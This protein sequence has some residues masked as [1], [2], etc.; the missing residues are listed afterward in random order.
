MGTPEK[1]PIAP[2][3]FRYRV[4]SNS[5]QQAL[6]DFIDP[7]IPAQLES[8]LVF[9]P[10]AI[11]ELLIPIIEYEDTNQ[12]SISGSLARCI[13]CGLPPHFWEY[14][15]YFKCESEKLINNG[16]SSALKLLRAL[17]HGPTD[18][19]LKISWKPI[20]DIVDR[21]DY[22]SRK[23]NIPKK[24]IS[25]AEQ[26]YIY[27]RCNPTLGRKKVPRDI[28]AYVAKELNIEL[29]T[30]Q[31][32][33]EEYFK[34]MKTRNSC[35]KEQ[36]RTLMSALVT[37]FGKSEKDIIKEVIPLDDDTSYNRETV[38]I[39][40][41]DDFEAKI[42][43]SQVPTNI[44]HTFMRIGILDTRHEGKEIFHIDLGEVGNLA[45]DAFSDKRS[46]N[47]SKIQDECT[48]PLTTKNGQIIYQLSQRA[49]DV[50]YE[51]DEIYTELDDLSDVMEV[52][53]RALRMNLLH[54]ISSMD[55]DLQS[56]STEF[57][58]DSLFKL[59]ESIQG[60]VNRNDTINPNVLHILQ[61]ELAL[62]LTINPHITV[63]FLRDS[64]LSSFIPGL[65]N[66]T[67]QQWNKI[68]SSKHFI[69]TA[70]NNYNKVPI[71]N[72]RTWEV[73]NRQAKLYQ[74]FCRNKHG[75]LH[76]NGV[77]R[78]INAIN[79]VRGFHE[80]ETVS[81]W[82]KYIDL[83]KNERVFYD[84]LSSGE[85]LSIPL[86]SIILTK[87]G[88][89]IIIPPES[90]QSISPVRSREIAE[91]IASYGPNREP[92][93]ETIKQMEKLYPYY[94]QAS[95]LFIPAEFTKSP[96]WKRDVARIYQIISKFPAG[97]TAREI[98][99]LLYHVDYNEHTRSSYFSRLFLSLKL[100][101]AIQREQ[102]IRFDLA[103][104]EIPVELYSLYTGPITK[105]T[106]LNWNNEMLSAMKSFKRQ[107]T[108]IAD[109]KSYFTRHI[110]WIKRHFPSYPCQT[111]LS[112]SEM[113]LGI[114]DH[115]QPVAYFVPN[116]QK[117]IHFLSHLLNTL[118]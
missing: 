76:F 6:R 42:I 105:I 29:T 100:I 44:E 49:H 9:V 75:E 110:W 60:F 95:L 87:Y 103:G 94:S 93:N 41:H 26:N 50:M 15:E 72:Q 53:L 14:P 23:L 12:L 2:P 109:L 48:C 1:T 117:S 101:G 65:K 5:L 111:I 79:E 90:L 51:S 55:I 106:D 99:K 66:I 8:R 69:I 71:G 30:L 37:H 58:S 57:T 36:M 118:Q 39:P 59:R 112:L 17:E 102:S 16:D 68:L 70:E 40:L 80:T 84:E 45:E 115:L 4:S 19:D 64:G 43:V 114:L 91:E 52:S 108:P 20:E 13:V 78:F 7:I 33:N 89:T 74:S 116:M 92:I 107:N 21:K 88:I 38:T 28:L 46:G 67:R 77:E 86:G 18:M 113:D 83:W 10:K 97:L 32:V 3:E 24:R 85:S 98:V 104:K 34:F 63:Q 62:C 27:D 56:F 73:M 82:K 31:S 54:R 81:P 96:E 25:S 61:R 47:S 35:Y 22:F 11:N